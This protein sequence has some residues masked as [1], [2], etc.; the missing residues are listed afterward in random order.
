LEPLNFELQMRMKTTRVL[1]PLL[2]ILSMQYPGFAQENAAFLQPALDYRIA[3]DMFRMKNMG[4]ARQL[5]GDISA[6]SPS[7]DPEI[8]T[9]SI[10]RE[11][12][13]AAELNNLDAPA[14][15]S[16][17]AEE[18]PENAQAGEVNLFLGKI[19]FKENKFKDAISS[20]QKVKVSNLGKNARE[21]LYFM[22]GYSQLKTGETSSAKAYFQRISNN[23]SPYYNQSRYF[24]AHIDFTQG[25]YPQALKAFEELESDSRYE[26][27]IP[28]YKIQ[29]YHY[30]GDN[31]KV[32]ALGPSLLESSAI[33]NKAEIARITGNAFFNI[34]DFTNAAIY[35]DIYEKTNRRS[36][37]R[38]DN[39]L[40]GFVS[41]KAGEYKN[42]I[43]NLQKAVKQD[44]ALSQN[45]SYYLGVCYNETGQKKYAGNA[46]LAAYK[47]GI[48]KDL[49]EESLFNYIKISLESPA[50]PYNESISLL[51][52]YLQENPGSK[53]A[54]EGY[55]YLSS[56]YLSS[57]N[58]KQALTSIETISNKNTKMKEAY[59]KILFYRAA[60]LFNKQDLD[61]AMELYTKASEMTSDES[62]RV[63]SLYWMGEIF[64]LQKN[65]WAAI[66]Y[67]KDF[68]NSKQAKKSTLY[69]GANYSLGYAHFNRKEYPEAIVCFNK[70]LESGQAGDMKL[71]SDAYLRLGDAYFISK[72]YDKAIAN[73]DKVI[74]SRESSMDYALYHKALSEGAKGDFNKKIDVLKVLINNYPKSP[75]NDDAYYETALAYILLNQETQALTYFD[76]LVQLYPTSGKAIQASLRKGFI[77]FNRNEFAQAIASFKTVI[78]KFP[79]TQEAQEALAAL[80]NIYIETGEVDKYYTYAKTLSFAEVNATEE[81]SLSY[82]VANNYYMQG[83]CAQAVSS[84]QK[85]LESFPDGA[86]V[87]DALYFQ[88]ECQLKSNQLPQA[89]EGFKKVAEKPRSRFTEPALATAASLEYSSG[90]YSAALPLFE[91][92]EV[93]AEDPDNAVAS[94][95]GQMR[96]H[97]RAGNFSAA[98][99][100][101]QKLLSTGKASTELTDEIHFTLGRCYLAQDDLTQA[102]Y[103]FTFTSKLA[104]TES[105]AEASY[106]LA[107]I[108]FKTGRL[109][110]AEERVYTLS[111]KFAAHD[112]WVAKGFILLSDIFLKNG[113]EFQAR[114]TL[115]SVID[116]YKGP[117][118]GEIAK[119]KLNA[120]GNE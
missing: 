26:K 115:Q 5:Y 75:Y 84:F 101:A 114:E 28:I 11:A 1:F 34:G 46:F 30:M 99:L 33:T 104:G 12:I 65:Y 10:L 80:K 73:Y 77:Y 112:Y 42:A 72:Q 51:E 108:A 109:T 37:S 89:L 36:L 67:Y 85:Y 21:E 70:F 110:E 8:M 32:M 97:Y 2:L 78:E 62:I 59:Q 7:T 48:D 116:N 52:N 45:A 61:G 53:R 69:P 95:T 96:C 64:Y 90:N 106:N 29:I 57:Q 43:A 14:L 102:E 82:E 25:N 88:A 35:L 15:L 27:V 44:D 22:M 31:E 68:I 58:Y 113:N 107:D 117:E 56:L 100:A 13:S 55:G 98:A 24:L 17:F 118:L 19:Y 9:G 111:E 92:L 20:L 41:Y 93:V 120:L 91:Q 66:K 6:G 18:Y 71:V 50:N 119:E 83:R 63:E 86:F 87:P 40:L 74:V 81:D 94:I 49:A 54:D 23:K 16:N 60:E 79:A 39:Y 105:G 76:K 103:E 38:E 47:N 3:D 4:S